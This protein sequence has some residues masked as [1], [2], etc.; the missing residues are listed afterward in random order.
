M[1]AGMADGALDQALI[2][3]VRAVRPD[4]QAIYRFGSTLNGYARPDSDIDVALLLPTPLGTDE[5][6]RIVVES[7]G[8]LGRDLDLM[9]LRAAGPVAHYQ[10]LSTG[11][12]I[13]IADRSATRAFELRALRDYRDYKVRR[14]PITEH[15]LRHGFAA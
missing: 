12:P 2:A 7:A 9:D 5:L 8:K 1:M 6:L 15:Y 14:R 11:H 3:A 10:V 4:V 13:H